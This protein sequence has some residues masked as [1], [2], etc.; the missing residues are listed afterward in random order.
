MGRVGTTGAWTWL[1]VVGRV[2]LQVGVA[3]EGVE[4][5]VV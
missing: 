4:V 3:G 5:G 2:G 1:A